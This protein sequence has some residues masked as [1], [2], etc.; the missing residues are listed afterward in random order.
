MRINI[1]ARHVEV[2]QPVKDYAE[3]R[4]GRFPHYFD[5]V[6]G[7]EVVLDREGSEFSCEFHVSAEGHD[8]FVA[9]A[10]DRD[11]TTSIDLA[12]DKVVRQLNDWK[13]R[14]RDNHH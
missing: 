5:K 4:A 10:G 3:E 7:V 6:S 13:S 12:H 1:T 14:L 8:D 9:K 11:M 2:K